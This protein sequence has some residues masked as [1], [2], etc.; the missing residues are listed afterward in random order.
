MVNIATERRFAEGPASPKKHEGLWSS[1]LGEIKEAK[2]YI[3]LTPGARPFRSQ[4]YRA[5][6]TQRELEAE[7]IRRMLAAN[8]NRPSKSHW[9][10][11][12]LLVSKPD[13]SMRFC[14]DYRRL[15]ALTA[16]D[17]YPI[18]RIDECL[19]FLGT[20]KIFSALDAN[21]G[22][23]KMAVA[24]DSVDK[25]ASVSHSGSSSGRACHLA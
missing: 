23:W 9:A 10:S 12:V 18:P 20:A 17:H 8:V 7:E 22:Y 13:G 2:H 21:S 5:D 16:R 11:P 3:V 24:A 15:N 1:H 6:P 19:E 25:A 14:I 4:P